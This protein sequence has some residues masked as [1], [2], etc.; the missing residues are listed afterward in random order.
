MQTAREEL[1]F[2]RNWTVGIRETHDRCQRLLQDGPGQWTRQA[3]QCLGSHSMK[4]DAGRHGPV[5]RL[6]SCLSVHVIGLAILTLSCWRV[7][8]RRQIAEDWLLAW[9]GK[10]GVGNRP[11]ARTEV[12]TRHVCCTSA[13]S[14]ENATCY[15]RS[16]APVRSAVEMVKW[17][18]DDHG[19]CQA[20][21]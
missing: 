14:W 21:R 18:V 16:Q 6:C 19:P 17:R 2:T 5:S 9:T 4:H 3:M 1:T 8:L 7:A 20:W 10:V 11:T 15:T 13:C 12:V